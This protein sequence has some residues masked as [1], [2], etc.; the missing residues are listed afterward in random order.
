MG[1]GWQSCWSGELSNIIQRIVGSTSIIW[2]GNRT[3]LT[4]FCVCILL[5]NILYTNTK[6]EKKFKLIQFI[7]IMQGTGPVH[8]GLIQSRRFH[9]SNLYHVK[10][11]S[12]V[13]KENLCSSFH[14]KQSTIQVSQ[15]ILSWHH[16]KCTQR[17]IDMNSKKYLWL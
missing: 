10:K 1:Q 7:P 12:L 6:S 16:L 14:T 11:E 5:C 8:H 2:N 13:W 3:V 9:F 15:V 4:V 17:E